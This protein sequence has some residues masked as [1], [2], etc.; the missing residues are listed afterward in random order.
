METI[1]CGNKIVSNEMWQDFA[2]QKLG[3]FHDEVFESAEMFLVEGWNF[4]DII[5]CHPARV[6]CI[7][8]IHVCIN[9]MDNCLHDRIGCCQ[10]TGI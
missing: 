7:H 3:S 8:E 6:E 2:A 1:Y 10:S 9:I 5:F 4:I